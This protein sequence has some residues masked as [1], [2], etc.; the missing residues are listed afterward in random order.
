[1]RVKTNI[2]YNKVC[3]CSNRI[4]HYG[5]YADEIENKGKG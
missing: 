1:M 2:E 4:S 5:E 3:M